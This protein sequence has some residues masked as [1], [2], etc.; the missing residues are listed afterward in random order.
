MNTPR[1]MSLQ[2]LRDE[3]KAVVRRE[4]PAP[5]DAKQPSFNSVDALTRLLTPDNR[6]LLALIRDK[7]HSRSPIWQRCRSPATQS[8]ENS[9]E[10]GGCWFIRMT[11]SATAK[12]H[13]PRPL[14]K[15]S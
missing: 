10:I 8:H 3:M 15:S 9:G 13:H 14:R 4:K 12:K 5:A 7:N 1:I 11:P 2:E 6:R